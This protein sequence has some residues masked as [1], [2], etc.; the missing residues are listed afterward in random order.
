MRE[1]VQNVRLD[2]T[3]MSLDFAI[4]LLLI[5]QQQTFMETAQHVT[6]ECSLTKWKIVWY[7][8]K[9]VYELNKIMYVL[10]VILVSLQA[11]L[12]HVQSSLLVV[13][14]PTLQENVLVATLDI[15]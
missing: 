3:W 7:Y 12:E 9:I 15:I 1:I 8:Q 6:Q 13:A 5:V 4:F 10:N 11:Q 2:F 14:L